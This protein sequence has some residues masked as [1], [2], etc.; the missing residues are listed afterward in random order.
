MTAGRRCDPRPLAFGACRRDSIGVTQD[1][2]EIFTLSPKV[3]TRRPIP[4]LAETGG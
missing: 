2:F 4:E 1:G 3:G